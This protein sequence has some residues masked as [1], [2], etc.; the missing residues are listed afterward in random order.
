MI[1]LASLVT[2]LWTAGPAGSP[3]AAP[4]DEGPRAERALA[5]YQSMNMLAAASEFEGLWTDFRVPGYLFNAAVARERLGHE[6]HAY[7]HLREY[8]AASIGADEKEAAERRLQELKLRAVPLRVEVVG[9]DV[10]GLRLSAQKQP[11]GGTLE[12]DESLVAVPGAVGVYEVYVEAGEWRVTAS[13]PGYQDIGATVGARPGSTATIQLRPQAVVLS[14]ALVVGPP[15]ALAAGATIRFT[16]RAGGQPISHTIAGSQNKWQLPPG[17]YAVTVTAAGF[18]PANFDLDLLLD[19]VS[20]A[21]L[22]LIP[23][24]TPTEDEDEVDRRF[25]MGLGLTSGLLLVSGGVTVAISMPRFGAVRDDY[26]AISEQV[27][28]TFSG[29]QWNHA[30]LAMRQN[31][32]VQTAGFV[33]AGGGAGAGIAAA[34]TKMKNRR[35]VVTAEVGAG[36]VAL[37]GSLVVY[38]VVH[39]RQGSK[40]RADELLIEKHDDQDRPQPRDGMLSSSAESLNSGVAGSDAAAFFIGAGGALLTA[41]VIEWASLSRNRPR[42]AVAVGT[43]ASRYGGMLTISG[44]F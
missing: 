41:G 22:S 42:P 38:I 5:A 11:D 32:R 13:A 29:R 39:G 26:L 16:P 15:E 2:M 44:N 36:A 14:Y 28:V 17:S 20:P 33:L 9:G 34:L 19:K 21:P 8:L 12:I 7:L 40:L 6:A 24:A 3:A 10:Q 30:Y 4:A 31:V 27:P 18:E 23:V 25:T 43:T 37:I 1:L 35:R